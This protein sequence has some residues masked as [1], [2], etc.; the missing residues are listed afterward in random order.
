MVDIPGYRLV[1][2]VRKTGYNLLLQALREADEQPVIL[3]TPLEPSVGPREREQYRRELAILRRL[4]DVRG[5]PRP[6]AC[7]WSQGRPVLVLEQVRGEPLSESV[8]KPYEVSRFLTLAISLAS[9]LSDIHRHG[10]I[11]KDLKPS[12]IIAEPSGTARIIDFGLA[13]LQRREHLEAVPIHLIEGTLAYMSPEQTGRMNRTLDYRTDFYSLGVTFYELLTG[14]RPCQAHDT[15]EWF[16]AHMAQSPRPP[17]ELVPGLPPALS[18][19]VMKLLAKV[20]EERYQSADGLKADLER[21]QEDMRRG[22]V[23]P[24]T[25]G[26]KDHPSQFQ[27]PQALYGREA[28]V[29]TLL[30]GF[31]RVARS[32]KPELLL[33]RGYSG[34][35]K[36][37]LVNE[38]HKPVVRRHGFFLSGKFDPLQRDVP[39]A[40]LAQAIGGLVRQLLAGSEEEL[41]RWRERLMDVWEGHGQ[42]LVDLVPLLERLVGRQP[43]VPPLTPAEVRHHFHRVLLRFLGVFASREHPLVVFLDDLQWADAASLRLLQHLLT[44]PEPPPVLWLGA[45]RDNEV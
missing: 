19:L 42:L 9:T 25:L 26:Q 45:Y 12:N 7:E 14:V 3:K 5:V 40:T 22:A 38:L 13:S 29:H 34:M 21:C 20:A 27:P 17:R 8:G 1:G 37:S 31:E 18:A 32:G 33:V 43:A 16:H 39:Y 2:A 23:E 6:Y 4:E 11:H 41:A 36:S 15:L 30:E 10:I 24:F 35:G 28:H 44:H